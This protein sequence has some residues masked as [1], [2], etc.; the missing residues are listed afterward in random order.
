MGD[1]GRD[2]DLMQ[3]SI[4]YSVVLY[5]AFTI[6]PGILVQFQRKN[7]IKNSKRF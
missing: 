6:L 7:I 5:H 2:T 1:G 4:F 3:Y